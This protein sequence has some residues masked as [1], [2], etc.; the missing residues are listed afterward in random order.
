VVRRYCGGIK[1][2]LQ[3]TAEAEAY[4]TVLRVAVGFEPV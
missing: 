2:P 4:A 3:N 1:P